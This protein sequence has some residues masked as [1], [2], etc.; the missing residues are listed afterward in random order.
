M[1]GK[2]KNAIFWRALRKIKWLCIE[3]PFE[4][5]EK[6]VNGNA[7]D[8]SSSNHPLNYIFSKVRYNGR[9]KVYSI[10][11]TMCTPSEND[12]IIDIGVTPDESLKESNFFEQ[13]YPYKNKIT[14]VSI[15]DAS[16]LEQ[17]YNGLKFVQIEKNENFPFQDNEFDILFCNAVIEHVGSREEQC[18][19]IS[20]CIRISKKFFFQTPN[21]YFPLEMHTIIPFLHWLPMKYFRKILKLLKKDFFASEENLNLFTWK[22]LHQMVAAALPEQYVDTKIVDYSIK[23]F[24]W[25]SN[26]II[27]GM[28]EMGGDSLPSSNR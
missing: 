17:K 12:T 22:E 24:F 23:T 21:R 14:A 18:F 27:C 8:Y 6:S 20:E 1:I 5:D 11:V 4:I 26:M 15:E 16:F 7:I 9:K 28:K 13:F 3:R 2:V 10:F 25:P 19:F